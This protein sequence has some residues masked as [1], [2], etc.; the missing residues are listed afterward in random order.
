MSTEKACVVYEL[1][2]G[3]VVHQHFVIVLPGAEE[4]PDEEVARRSIE[5]YEHVGHYQKDLKVDALVVPMA[6]LHE[7]TIYKVDVATKQLVEVE[8]GGR[9]PGTRGS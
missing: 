9:R 8:Q 2:E 6:E 7:S 5:E 4:V 1:D 3:N